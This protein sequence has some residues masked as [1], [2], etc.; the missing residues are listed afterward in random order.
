[1]FYTVSAALGEV[2]F[3]SRATYLRG[4]PCVLCANIEQSPGTL[5]GHPYP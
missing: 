2:E 1:M 4:P 3:L 5:E